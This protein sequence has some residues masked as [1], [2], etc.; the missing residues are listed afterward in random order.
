MDL[1][2]ISLLFTGLITPDAETGQK[3]Q[4]NPFPLFTRK[5]KYKPKNKTKTKIKER[6]GFKIK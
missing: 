1:E 4:F 6:A 2:V 5:N 3:T